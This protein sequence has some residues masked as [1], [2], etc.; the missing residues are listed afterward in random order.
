MTF[1]MRLAV[2]DFFEIRKKVSWLINLQPIAFGVSFNL[3]FQ[4]ESYWSLFNG[5]GRRDVE[6]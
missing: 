2:K 1:Q 4:S 3:Y 5:T 6:N